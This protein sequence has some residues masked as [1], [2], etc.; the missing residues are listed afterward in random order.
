MPEGRRRLGRKPGSG[1]RHDAKD[2]R[3]RSDSAPEGRR[4][5]ERP[6][7]PPPPPAARA[8]DEPG[9]PTATVLVKAKRARPFFGRHPWVLDTAID[10]VEGTPADGD[11]VDLATHEGRF[12]ARGIWNASSR[13]RVR[14]YAFESDVPLDAPFWRSRIDAAIALRRTLGLDDRSGAARLINSEGDDL[15]GLV[16]DRYGDH[17]AIQVTGLAMAGRLDAIC[18]ALEAAVKPA[19]ILLRGADRGLSK[20]EGLHLPDRVIRGTAPE[21]PVFIREGSLSWGVDLTEGQK[22]GF[23]LDQRENRRAAALLARDRRVLDLF[24]YS[25]GFA[26][27]C[28]ITGSAR[29]VLAVDGSAKATA[30]ARAN[31]DF[32]GAA[33][34]AVETADAFARIDSLAATGEKFGMVILD[35]PKFARSRG[36]I[37]EALRAYH[38]INRVAV[39]LLEPGGILV[40]CSCSGSVSR[41]DFLEMLSAVAQRSGRQIA[42]LECRGAAPDHP[43]SASCLEGEYLK[44]VIARVA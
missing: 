35:P 40:S 15:S 11:V 22:T 2:Q 33:N 6:P 39:D 34:V 5:D 28:A 37:E 38:R 29:S 3:H 18:D 20:L 8:T 13:L 36:A 1:P 4:R 9:L 31:A 17:L 16:V 14:L 7:A 26:V 12:I 25:G 23:Y 41:D 21:G 24:C 44:C 10:R 42:M 27:T 32:N 19:G 43:V 30:L